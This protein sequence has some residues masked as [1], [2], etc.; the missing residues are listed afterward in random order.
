MHLAEPHIKTLLR[1]VSAL[2]LL[3]LDVDREDLR[4]FSPVHEAGKK[5]PVINLM[6]EA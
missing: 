1:F 5:H 3:S 4:R 6:L 2:S